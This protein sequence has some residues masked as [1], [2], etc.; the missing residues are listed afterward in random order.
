M[1]A[2][3]LCMPS[4]LGCCTAS[5]AA[6]GRQSAIWH[7]YALPSAQPSHSLAPD[8]CLI[9]LR[10]GTALGRE[11]QSCAR[12]AR[13]GSASSLP[14]F[15]PPSLPPSLP[16]PRLL[17]EGRGRAHLQV[18]LTLG[19]SVRGGS[20]RAPPA[21]RSTWPPHPAAAAGWH[22]SSAARRRAP[23]FARACM[24]L[25]PSW[26][27]GRVKL[28]RSC[29]SLLA[30]AA[31]PRQLQST[32]AAAQVQAAH[33]ST[34]EC[35]GRLAAHV[36]GQQRLAGVPSWRSSWPTAISSRLVDHGRLLSSAR[37]GQTREVTACNP[38]DGQQL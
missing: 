12:S 13:E 5:R 32:P 18:R 20:G 10:G 15:L 2:A 35:S 23:V 9:L 11:L 17:S 21:Q 27:S 26:S 37:S 4:W 16:Y 36:P 34:V 6:G 14:S 8:R 3:S 29:V 30:A 28:R 25:S 1:S 38:S 19:C 7:A 22:D 33:C 24:R 31:P